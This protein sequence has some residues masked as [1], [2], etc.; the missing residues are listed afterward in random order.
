MS[1]QFARLPAAKKVSYVKGWFST[2]VHH[3]EA[4]V[5]TAISELLQ[6]ESYSAEILSPRA[7]AIEG[8]PSTPTVNFWRI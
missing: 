4:G 2:L 8:T 7:A 1:L 3:C 6:N 5:S